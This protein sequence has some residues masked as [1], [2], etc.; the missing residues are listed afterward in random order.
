MVNDKKTLNQKTG[1]LWSYLEPKMREYCGEIL[2]FGCGAGYFS[3]YILDLGYRY[4][5]VDVEKEMLKLAS[6]NER[7]RYVHLAESHLPF[8]EIT[9][10]AVMA[11]TVLQHIIDNND[12][13]LWVNELSRVVRSGGM[14]YVID[15]NGQ[16]ENLSIP[17]YIRTPEEVAA[18]LNA[19]IISVDTINIGLQESYWYMVAEKY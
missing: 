2:D 8:E 11:I 1:R 7:A 5:G 13:K 17:R 14:F 9:F 16:S 3:G 19:S 4:V 15:D 10:D 18:S 6:E 12:Y